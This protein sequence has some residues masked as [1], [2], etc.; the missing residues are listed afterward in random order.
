[1]FDL[2][3]KHGRVIDPSQRIDGDFDVAVSAGRVAAVDRAIPREAAYRVIDAG[4]RLVLP[5]LIDFHTHVFHDFTYWGVEPDAI[6]CLTGVTTWV[7]AGSSGA[8]TL[9][10]FRRFIADDKAVAVRAFLNIAYIGLI[11][12]DF[13][14]RSMEYCDVD[15]FERMYRANSD[16]I[17]GVKVRMG[18]PT[19]GDNGVEPLRRAVSAAERCEL[20]VMVHIADAPP[21]I[22][23]VL[24][25][26]RPGDIITHCFSGATMKLV[27]DDGRVRDDARRAAES[28]VILDMGHGAGGMTFA[29]AEAMIAAG[30]KPHV[31]SSDLHQMSRHGASVITSDAADSAFIRVWDDDAEKFDLLACVDKLMALGLSLDEVVKAVTSAPAALIAARPDVGT[32]AVGA[33]ADLGIFDLQE[34]T[35]EFRDTVGEARSGTRRLVN[36]ATVIGGREME[37]QTPRAPAPWVDLVPRDGNAT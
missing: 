1:M 31:I 29:S 10:G 3:I 8:I 14:L 20:P 9:P 27:D 28:G 33:R 32:L 16:F 6:G 34:G 4:D 2:L 25:L 18:T 35:F 37:R 26:L 7:D 13:E 5:G 12:P 36:V 24:E 22:G 15:L 23:D 11:A 30:L 17:V 19:V 21:E